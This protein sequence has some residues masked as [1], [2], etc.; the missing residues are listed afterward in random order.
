MNVNHTYGVG[1]FKRDDRVVVMDL[2]TA[3]QHP[4]VVKKAT[5]PG[6]VNVQYDQG[7]IF[8]VGIGFVRHEAAES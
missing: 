4:G 3:T 6:Y 1:E 7:G 8:R 5:E 2:R